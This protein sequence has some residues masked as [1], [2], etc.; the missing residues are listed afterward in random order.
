MKASKQKRVLKDN[1]QELEKE[2]FL[3]KLLS[4]VSKKHQDIFQEFLSCDTIQ[5][6]NIVQF[7]RYL[8]LKEKT[9]V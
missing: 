7:L 2:Y 1:R 8:S 3:L 6:L 9:R 4:Q 5:K